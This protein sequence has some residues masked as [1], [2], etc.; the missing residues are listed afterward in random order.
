MTQQAESASDTVGT[1]P[2]YTVSEAAQLVR[3]T[4]QTLHRWLRGSVEGRD[5]KSQEPLIIMDD[6]EGKY[7]SFYNLTEASFL[8]AYRHEGTPM[9]RVRR[10]LEYTQREL[11]IKRPLLRATFKTDGRNL[12][13]KSGEEALINVSRSGQ[14]AWPVVVDRHFRKLDFDNQGPVLMW[15][16]DDRQTIGVTPSVSFGAPIVARRGIRTELI[17][18][19]FIA[20]ENP[21]EIAEDFMLYEE[22]VWDALRWENASSRMAA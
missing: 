14:Y 15:L 7:L 3:T 20:E 4:S 13:F 1:E 9:Q 12:F 22:E 6:P 11:D 19:R 8:A 16:F 21:R 17:A 18:E 10:A 5:R 2:R